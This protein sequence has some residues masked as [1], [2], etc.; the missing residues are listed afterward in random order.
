MEEPGGLQSM[1]SQRVGHDWATSLTHTLMCCAILSLSVMSDCDHKDCNLP[2]FSVHGDPPGKNTRVGCHPL[3]Q[4]IF[5]TQGLNPG[6]LHWRWILYHLSHQGSLYNLTFFSK[7]LNC[8]LRHHTNSTCLPENL[9][10]PPNDWKKYFP[11][12]KTY[13]LL[14]SIFLSEINKRLGWNCLI[15]HPFPLYNSFFTSHRC[16]SQD[17]SPVNFLNVNLHLR[18]FFLGNTIKEGWIQK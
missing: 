6:L 2:G 8:C 13:F 16:W 17:H 4:R 3:L 7:L 5:K 12:R 9:L 11:L 14:S 15:H 18:V 10:L 1:G